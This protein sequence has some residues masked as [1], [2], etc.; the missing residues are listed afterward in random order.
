VKRRFQ[1]RFTADAREDLL[2]LHAFMAE[3]SPVAATRAVATI[4]RAISVLEEFPW[5]CRPSTALVGG[6]FRE[7][8]IPF[9]RQGYVALF[10]IERGSLVGVT[11]LAVRSQRESDDH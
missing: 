6:H 11:V 10:E 1:V 4:E 3:R 2:E 9:G 7:F 8:I 5:S